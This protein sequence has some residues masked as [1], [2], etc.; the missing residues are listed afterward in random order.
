M[1]TEV[2][3]PCVV[4]GERD[5]RRLHALRFPDRGYPG[6]FEIRCCDGCGLLF[7]SPRLSDPEIEALY[8][9]NYYVFQ[10]READA[11][12]RVSQLLSQTLGVATRHVDARDVLEVG[13]AKGYLLAMLKARG[14]RVQGVE[15][16]ADAAAFARARFGLNVFTGTVEAWLHSK[17]FRPTPLVLCTDVIE[18][19][20][21]PAA[22]VDALHATILPGGWLVLGT[23]NADSDHR[24]TLGA[25]W[26]AF[27]PFH[28]WIFS[29]ANLGRL[30]DR[31]GFDVV[32]AYT[33][34][35][36]DPRKAGA[37]DELRD[38]ARGVLRASGLLGT[39]R[40]VR[41]RLASTDATPVTLQTMEA[42]VA[43]P[44]DAY[45]ASPDAISARRA[46]CRGDDLVVIARRRA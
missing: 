13:C 15:L 16:S 32:E 18:H 45:L 6:W 44:L 25:R 2:N 5:S 39:V 26:V 38:A 31:A 17:A 4:C 29:R 28:I 10:E 11:V 37:A 27:N 14:W 33:C 20:T 9:A 40:R 24:A 30:L 22:F 7:N 3:L 1:K 43:Q 35:N 36:S 34:S 46:A 21:D 41:D 23:P 12:A 8:G 19:V 42:T